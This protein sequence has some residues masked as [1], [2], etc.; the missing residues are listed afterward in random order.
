M[1]V[2]P[3]S[4]EQA[5][6][7][8]N[9][10]QRYG[11]WME[12]ERAL[13]ALPYDLRRKA[14]GD[15]AYL[16]EIFDRSGNGKSLGAWSQDRRT[17]LARYRKE[18]ASAKERRRQSGL[19]LK[20]SGRLGRALRLGVLA[21]VAGQILREA[22]RRALL[23]TH[24]LVVGTNALAAY[25]VE[26][27]GFIRG[28]PEETDDF[29]LAWAAT[30]AVGERTLWEMLKAVDDTFTVNME[31]TFQARNANAYEVEVVVAPSRAST[32]TRTDRPRPLPLP[33]QEWLLRGAAVDRVVLCR[34][35]SAARIV[36]PDPRWFA[37]QKLWLGRQAK[38]N[39]LKRAKD[40]K[41]GAAL[42][43]AVK[44]AMPQYPLNRAFE[45]SLP[46][47]LADAYARWK[48]GKP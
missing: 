1:A 36:A 44:E 8:S 33:E 43:D 17:Q 21:N 4:E 9:L 14:V 40:R 37:L 30:E 28:A 11:V 25:A 7:L 38:R 45:R 19:R 31:R 34:D 13:A 27:G 35:G 42:L 20:E 48:A 47:E 29:D 15:K 22:D 26:A 24:L 41:Q 32:I 16:Y 10:E 2:E 5:R 12:A 18:K 23:G 46:A 3:L 39:A 6:A